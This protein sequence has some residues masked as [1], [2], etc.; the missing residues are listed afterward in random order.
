M[1]EESEPMESDLTEILERIPVHWG[2]WISCGPGWYPLVIKTHKMLDYLMPGYEIHQVKEKY[3]QLRFYWGEPPDTKVDPLV[4]EIAYAVEHE[5]EFTSGYVCDQC[6]DPARNRCH[7]HWYRT[8]C[9]KCVPL[10]EGEKM[11]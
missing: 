9:T 6:G 5:S 7:N 3:G 8:V 2:R 4:R 1:N 11:P 10:R